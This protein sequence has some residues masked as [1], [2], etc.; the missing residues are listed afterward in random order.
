MNALNRIPLVIFFVASVGVAQQNAQVTSLNTVTALG[1]AELEV[2]PDIANLTITVTSTGKTVAAAQLDNAGKS[3]SVLDAFKSKFNLKKGDYK[4]NI[5]ESKDVDY[6]TNK[7]V[8][9]GEIVKNTITIKVHELNQLGAMIDAAAPLGAETGYVTY[10]LEDSQS[11]KELALQKAALNAKANAQALLK[12]YGHDVGTV[13][14]VVQSGASAPVIRA[15]AG[16]ARAMAMAP[17]GA[18]PS[19]EVAT[20]QIT[21]SASATV[22]FL[23]K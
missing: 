12:A 8:V 23:I 16:Q 15:E 17:G 18:A 4:N 5:S 13:V 3:K 11:V 2:D 14:A 22:V 20:G 21:I 19:T 10:G 7:A 6:S 1:S 9:R